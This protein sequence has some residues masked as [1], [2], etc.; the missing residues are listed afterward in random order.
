MPDDKRYPQRILMTADTVGGVWNYVL[1]LAAGLQN[2][3]IEVAL[4]TMGAE[5]NHSQ[6]LELGRL[7]NVTLFES[8]YKLEWMSEPWEEVRQAGEWLLELE[9]LVQPDLVHLNGY[10]HAVLKW[11]A[12]TLVVGH[13]CV[14]SWWEA[15]K[16]QTAPEEWNQYRQIV[17]RGLRQASLVVAPSQAMLVALQA[18]YGP[19]KDSLVI[20]NG[21]K[22]NFYQ[23]EKLPQ[24]LSVGRLWDEAKNIAALERIGPEL[25]WPVYLA[26]EKIH[27]EGGQSPLSQVSL[28][29]KLSETELA[30]WYG[31]SAIYVLPAFYEPFGL[32]ILEA[33]LAGCALVLGD[34]PSLREIWNGAALFIPP[35]DDEALKEAITRLIGRPSLREKLAQQAHLRGREY[36]P[37]RMTKNYLAAYE[38][39]ATREQLEPRIFQI[40]L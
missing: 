19:F 31:R 22:L 12:P 6:C 40:S 25:D 27:P 5:L 8:K 38:S 4:A 26:G 11:Q 30:G 39:L 17:G 34:I 29:G 24:I 10:A 36:T 18:L 33:G 37:E 2:Y 3:G 7:S 16:Q 35:G 32:S 14:L 21:R 1:E 9:Q 28:L 20:Y 23:A 15:V 13:S